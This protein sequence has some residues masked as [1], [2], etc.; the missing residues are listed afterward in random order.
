MIEA[1]R[2]ASATSRDASPKNSPS[3]RARSPKTCPRTRPPTNSARSSRRVSPA[4]SAEPTSSPPPPPP[5]RRSNARDVPACGGGRAIRARRSRTSPTRSWRGAS[6][7]CRCW[8]SSPPRRRAAVSTASALG[9]RLPDPDADGSCVSESEFPRARR[10]APAR[11]PS[12]RPPA[13]SGACSNDV[14]A[15]RV[16]TWNLRNNDPDPELR[17]ANQPGA[18]EANGGWHWHQRVPVVARVLQR[19]APHVLCLQEDTRA[20]ARELMAS[21]EM[22][23]GGAWSYACFPPPHDPRDREPGSAAKKKTPSS[24]TLKKRTLLDARVGADGL[25][26]SA[27]FVSEEARALASGAASPWEQCAVWWR[28]D[29]FEFVD[30]G[31]FEWVDGRALQLAR[32]GPGGA[33]TWRGGPGGARTCHMCPL[34]WWRFARPAEAACSS[35]ARRTRVRPRLGLGRPREAL[36]RGAVRAAV[37][38]LQDTFGRDVPVLVAGDFNAEDA[39]APKDAHGRERG[40]DARA[41]PSR[42]IRRRREGTRGASD[43][44]GT[45]RR[46][47]SPVPFRRRRRGG[48][49]R[50]RALRRSGALRRSRGKRR[51]GFG[52]RLRRGRGGRPRRDVHGHPRR[53]RAHG[54]P[55]R[56]DL[57]QLARAGMGVHGERA[58]GRGVQTPRAARVRR[59]CR[60]RRRPSRRRLRPTAPRRPLPPPRGARER[61]VGGGFGDRIGGVGVANKRVG[62][63]GHQ[64]HIDH[65]Y[66][67][68]GEGVRD[69]EPR[70]VCRV[71]AVRARRGRLRERGRTRGA[72]RGGARHRGREGEGGGGAVRSGERR[73]RRRRRTADR[74]FRAGRKGV[75]AR[76]ACACGPDGVWASD[77]FPVVADLRVSWRDA[78]AEPRS[79]PTRRD[80]AHSPERA[81]RLR[82][83]WAFEGCSV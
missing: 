22:R 16:M 21:E 38:A 43:G 2:A 30:G 20:M 10:R 15:V 12:R 42:R 40:V 69:A 83:E 9:A 73:R 35:R 77:H 48:E 41:G 51:L 57:A 27:A 52:G 39:V 78:E 59:P 25:V 46:R 49:P 32:G 65:V 23:R 63:V 18:G 34:T 74:G 8:T 70:R 14:L 37:A 54:R 33:R 11:W 17:F 50:R 64:R 31:Q 36:E 5:P 6:R 68:R 24:S 7:R 80:A 53:W 60:A 56:D 76:G 79:R 67:A 75:F 62:A 45:R 71:R 44:E 72:R 47:V 29:A 13:A 4:S 28:E 19:D 1:E 3:P 58:D 81:E 26:A 61:G 82:S 66:V 55:P